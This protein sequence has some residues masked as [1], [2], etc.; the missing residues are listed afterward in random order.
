M[1]LFS[2]FNSPA[3]LLKVDSWFV[4]KFFTN[5]GY[6]ED[7]PGNDL[8]FTESPM[9]S[10]SATQNPS[11]KQYFKSVSNQ[12]SIGSCH[13]DKTE[14]LTING[15]KL[16]KDIKIEDKLAS[17][18]PETAELI[19]ANPEKLI[20]FYYK[21]DMICGKNK[22]TL[23]FKVTPDHNMLIRTWNEKNRSLNEQYELIPAKDMGWY[24]GLLNRIHWIGNSNKNIYT[25]NSLLNSKHKYN[26]KNINIPIS[27]WL[28]FLGIYLAEGTIITTEKMNRKC[29][30]RIQI[31][32]CKKREKEFIKQVLSEMNI[33]ATEYIDRFIINHKRLYCA[34]KELNL[35]N[36][37][38]YDKFV[39]SFVFEECSENI[40]LF[41]LG[42]FM[43]D[44]S[45]QLNHKC[46]YTSSSKLA[47][48]LQRLIF[49]SGDES[50]ISY[51]APRSCAMKDGR[52]I[53]GKH[54]EYRVSVCSN[55]N[56]SIY[57]KKNISL[58]HYEG[59]V[60]CAEINPYHTLVT[61]RNGK[62]LI[63]GNCVAN[64]TA[65][66]LE[67][68]IAHRQ[69]IDPA[70]VEDLSRLFIYWNARNLDTPPTNNEDTGSH[71]RLAFDS[72]ARYGVP[73][74]RIYPYDISKVNDRPTIIAYREAIK[75]RISKF[76]RITATG[77]ERIKQIKQALCAGNPV[78]FGT[79]VA[80][81]FKSIR[82]DRVITN[83]GGWYIGGHCMVIVG[84][85]EEK[86]AFEV[87]NS[88]GEGWG[89]RGYCWMDKN[90]IAANITTDLWVP[91]V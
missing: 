76:Y 19:Y 44:G 80:E 89:N 30:Y 46:H 67:A 16:F 72:V 15:W 87:R 14:V 58:E 39:P 13:D 47:E 52:I 82:D 86:Q 48:D 50:Y 43:G 5:F 84:W 8:N 26:H 68:Q 90:Y 51:R 71:I 36:V 42:H 57:N 32:A 91:T 45:E 66:A 29:T 17:I 69:G 77:E 53:V 33:K 54:N 75:N 56:S 70:Q 49:L 73:S 59:E 63:S 1:A 28:K 62:I 37:K 3:E 88:W 6:K 41:L 38:S 7:G 79:K 27:A 10:I 31:A 55:K 60:F 35:C 74:E 81:S 23:D 20:R 61:R 40:K 22:Y 21:G 11:L 25:I 9:A 4:S 34:L 85:S 12:Y 18:N 65:D 24:C 2:K 78:V 64:G 83:P